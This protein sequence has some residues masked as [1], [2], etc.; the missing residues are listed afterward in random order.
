MSLTIRYG[1]ATYAIH[2]EFAAL[3]EPQSP[4]PGEPHLIRV[5]WTFAGTALADGA[6]ALRA[7][8]ESLL[9]ALTPA[10][11]DLVLTEGGVEADRID[12]ASAVEGPRL[13]S[14]EFPRALPG[15]YRAGLDFH[16]VMEALLP[17]G[18]GDNKVEGYRLRAETDDAGRETLIKE[19][20]IDVTDAANL[21]AHHAAADPG[22]PNGWQRTAQGSETAGDGRRVD[23][24]FENR[25]AF[26]DL[27]AGVLSGGYARAESA[28]GGA[29]RVTLSGLFFGPLARQAA[30]ALRPAGAG[31][32]VE[33][34]LE[35]NE[36]DRSARFRYVS[37][38][39]AAAA[40]G[41]G[42]GD[43]LRFSETFRFATRRTFVDHRP[44]RR[45]AA[46]Y[47][48]EIGGPVYEVIQEGEAAG[49]RAWPAPSAPL[50]EG[51]LLEQ[52][53]R[54]DAPLPGA[55]GAANPAAYPVRWRYRMTPLLRP[56]ARPP[57]ARR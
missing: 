42:A 20:R 15:A 29:R 21:A 50:S 55:A 46:P 10:G 22:V 24:R 54:Y 5:R 23:Y 41:A 18:E 45:G 40:N 28:E 6:A 47:R 30:E 43:L 9:A 35:V 39:P 3:R 13:A 27:P 49:A 53:V 8:R 44:L 51:D 36:F 48:Q 7:A 33:E 52:E 1:D 4:Q 38:E 26:R 34:S 56:V 57:P 12:A 25:R 31:V 32:V 14:I 11:R 2:P 16:A 17:A 19:G 37:D